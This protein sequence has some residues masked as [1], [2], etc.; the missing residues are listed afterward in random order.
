MGIIDS[1][2]RELRTVIEWD[3]RSH[4]IMFAR[5]SKDGDEIKN[6]SQ[7]IVNPGQGCV[8]VY[9]G[10]VKNVFVQEGRY[11]LATGNVPF[12]TTVSRFMQFFESEH[13]VGLFFFR[14]T[15]FVNQKWGTSSDIKYLDPHFDFPVALRA[16]GNYSVQI[17][18][19]YHFFHEFVG[20]TEYYMVGEFR[21]TMSQRIVQ[22]IAD[23]LA[24]Q[25]HAYHQI[26][27]QLDEISAALSA[28][29]NEAFLALG[30]ELK[31]FR[32]EGTTFD[33]ETQKR[34]NRISDVKAEAMAAKEIGLDYRELQE[35]EALRDAARNEGGTAG[36]GVAMGAGLKMMD[37]FD[38]HTDKQAKPQE[39]DVKADLRKLKEIFDEGLI[40]QEEYSAKKEQLLARL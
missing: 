38:F 40:T 4:E 11:E 32:I 26:D 33:D 37:N 12:W 35:T 29:M 20:S 36:V 16:Y 8:F 22:H 5:W 2:R 34:I 6:A 1:I 14:T 15:Q 27:S 31:D 19:P 30:F 21:Q 18:N 28:R 9:E 13:K 25:R 10:E 7:L 3:D 24:G 17:V 39:H 23:Y